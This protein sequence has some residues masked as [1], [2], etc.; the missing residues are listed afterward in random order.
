MRRRVPP[1]LMIS[2]ELARD[3]SRLSMDLGR[4]LGVLIDRTGRI[5]VVIVGDKKEIVIPV[6]PMVR[7]A[8]GRLKGLR[9]VHTHLGGEGISED[10]LMDL[11]FLRLDL[12]VVI[13][14]QADGLP[15]RL[16][17]VHLAPEQE[18]GKNWFFLPPVVP[19][20]QEP[21]CLEVITAI[22]G[23]FAKFQP[24]SKVDAG[25]DRAS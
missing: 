1:D 20:Q 23:Q 21:T 2:A 6:L 9:C 12:M 24:L 13:K 10:D 25:R 7:S 4:Q 8:G 15:E 22:E 19:S 11:L 16:Y 17:P 18:D 5:E 3:L 14:V